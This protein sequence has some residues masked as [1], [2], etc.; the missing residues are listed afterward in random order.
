[1][2][3]KGETSNLHK[4]LTDLT[5]ELDVFTGESNTT[6][7]CKIVNASLNLEV[8]QLAKVLLTVR[9]INKNGLVRK[10]DKSARVFQKEIYRLLKSKNSI[11]DADSHPIGQDLS[12]FSCAAKSQDILNVKRLT[13][14]ISRN[15]DE[16]KRTPFLQYIL[17]LGFKN[18]Y[19]EPSVK[20]SSL[21]TNDLT[22][23]RLV[24]S[25]GEGTI[26][27]A[28][29]SL[30]EHELVRDHIHDVYILA[31]EFRVIE[32]YYKKK[33]KRLQLLVFFN[34]SDLI[35]DIIFC[36]ELEL[37]KKMKLRPCDIFSNML[38]FYYC[39]KS[40]NFTFTITSVKDLRIF[41]LVYV[42][43][44]IF[45]HSS[46]FTT[47][48]SIISP[49]PLSGLSYCKP[50]IKTQPKTK[51]VEN[52]SDYELTYVKENGEEFL[53]NTAATP[54]T[55]I[56]QKRHVLYTVNQDRDKRI[57]DGYSS[58]GGVNSSELIIEPTP[59]RTERTIKLLKKLSKNE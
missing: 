51:L 52:I 56:N 17:K 19:I 27:D 24:L 4:I 32:L 42:M 28:F 35:E 22:W 29:K 5:Y 40:N 49:A 20:D 46:K 23:F 34:E 2:S 41:N 21:H 50:M 53:C 8:R 33:A 14:N 37:V 58:V 15:L 10:N 26:L 3:L 55:F 9:K 11:D 7:I 13:E 48:N 1:M 47:A 59:E 57:I 54:E 31:E 39:Y 25:G 36:S 6:N 30:Y 12:I 44:G 16:S 45:I 18:D 43:C 38:K